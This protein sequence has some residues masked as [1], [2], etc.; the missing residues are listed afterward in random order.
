[1]NKQLDTNNHAVVPVAKVTEATVSEYVQCQL[2]INRNSCAVKCINCKN[3]T[4][5]GCLMKE[6]KAAGGNLTKEQAVMD[7][8]FYRI[9]QI[10]IHMHQV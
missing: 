8:R 9:F 10:D 1:M 2:M 3:S 4:Y 5:L 6:F 7:T